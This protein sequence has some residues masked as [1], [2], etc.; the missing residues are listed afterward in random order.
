M[1]YVGQ[2]YELTVAWPTLTPD[3]NTLIDMATKF[4]GEHLR[5]YSYDIQDRDIELVSLRVTVTAAVDRPS[6]IPLKSSQS[7]PKTKSQRMVH[8][9]DAIPIDCAVY[10]RDEIYAGATLEGPI[11][12]EQKDS[13]TLVPPN[14]SLTTAP[15]GHLILNF[16]D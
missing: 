13:T 9:R 10:E 7:M 3:E 8:F 15:S 5:H 14:W 12:I 4:H 2:A 16:R 1:R 6:E 11:V